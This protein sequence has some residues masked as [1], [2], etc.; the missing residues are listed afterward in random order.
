MLAYSLRY[1]RCA[2]TS[3]RLV[4]WLLQTAAELI[5]LHLYRGRTHSDFRNRDVY[6]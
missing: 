3:A 4:W 6:T 1:R 2:A 5:H